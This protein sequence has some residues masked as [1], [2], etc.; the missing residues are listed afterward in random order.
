MLQRSSVGG[1]VDEGEDGPY[2]PE[3][4]AGRCHQTE[5]DALSGA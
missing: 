4:A 2:V 5:G 1:G 3:P